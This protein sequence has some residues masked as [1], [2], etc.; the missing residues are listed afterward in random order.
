M[1]TKQ[2]QNLIRRAKGDR[3]IRA[4][5]DEWAVDHASLYKIMTGERE[6]NDDVLKALRLYRV[7]SY[8]PR[9]SK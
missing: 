3:S 9:K 4:L 5:A 1:D 6:P 8:M 7:V 2:V